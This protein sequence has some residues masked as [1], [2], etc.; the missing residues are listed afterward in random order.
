MKP[1]APWLAPILALAAVGLG[2]APAAAADLTGV[3]RFT[4]KVETFGFELE[5]RFTQKG[6]DLS[7]VCRDMATNDPSHKPQGSHTLTVG[8]VDGDRVSFAYRTHF[9]LIPFTA[10]YAGTVSGD[11][12]S[13]E[14]IAPGHRGSFS[15]VRS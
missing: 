9:L 13:G 6:D 4:C 5:C 3:W 1:V 8:H 15:A 11:R 2:A 14:A 7:G 10:S 12:M